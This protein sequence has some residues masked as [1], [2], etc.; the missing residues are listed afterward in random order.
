MTLA[1][2]PPTRVLGGTFLVT[3]EP[4]ATTEFSPTVT[5]PMIGTRSSDAIEPHSHWHHHRSMRHIIPNPDLHC[6][7]RHAPARLRARV[8]LLGC[9]RGRR[10]L[11]VKWWTHASAARFSMERANGWVDL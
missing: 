2:F 3:T 8:S 5:P 1:G 9:K 6:R 7:H 11:P 4:A 10:S